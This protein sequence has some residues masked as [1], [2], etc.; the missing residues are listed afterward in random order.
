VGGGETYGGGKAFDSVIVMM[1]LFSDPTHLRLLEYSDKWYVRGRAR[2]YT[3]CLINHSAKPSL[4]KT[5]LLALSLN[6]RAHAQEQESIK[7]LPVGEACRWGAKPS[8]RI[9]ISA[10]HHWTG[11]P[12]F[13]GIRRFE[14]RDKSA[15]WMSSDICMVELIIGAGLFYDDKIYSSGSFLLENSCIGSG[16]YRYLNP[17]QETRAALMNFDEKLK[18]KLRI[19]SRHL[20]KV[21]SGLVFFDQSKTRAHIAAT[22]IKI[23]CGG[24]CLFLKNVSLTIHSPDIQSQIGNHLFILINLGPIKRLNIHLLSTV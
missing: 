23:A 7:L 24:L 18:V 17:G 16:V 4:I 3:W 1:I 22:L 19:V 8:Q 10:Y 14:I 6:A 12:Q 20:L 5:Y 9:L 2:H 11:G 13:C 15:L 21:I